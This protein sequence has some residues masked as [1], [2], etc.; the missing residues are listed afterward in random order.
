MVRDGGVRA[1]PRCRLRI[2]GG[3]GGSCEGNK[4]R[5][6]PPPTSAPFSPIP[7]LHAQPSL[8]V[9]RLFS[10]THVC[11]FHPAL[12]HPVTKGLVASSPLSFIRQKTYCL[13]TFHASFLPPPPSRACSLLL[14]VSLSAPLSLFWRRL[15]HISQAGRLRA[16]DF[17]TPHSKP[18]I[19]CFGGN[20]KRRGI[21][22]QLLL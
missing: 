5:Q 15:L 17:P 19:L 22:R 20:I 2:G 7:C 8:S 14:P 3:G 13:A 18:L 4:H 6:Y 1:V 16:W 9:K 11:A 12:R 21:E 10:K